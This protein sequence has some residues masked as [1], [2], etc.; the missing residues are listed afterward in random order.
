[1][2]EAR[3]AAEPAATAD[4]P[5]EPGEP[6]FDD[7]YEDRM[8]RGYLRPDFRVFVG[9]LP[10]VV[11]LVANSMWSTQVAIAASFV[12]ATIVF[13]R[14]PGSGVIRALTMVSFVVVFASAVVGLAL[15]SGK[16]FVAQNMVGDFLIAAIFTGSVIIGRPM[17][18][19][20]AREMVPAIQPIMAIDHQVFVKLTLLNAGVNLVTG[21]MRLFLLDALTENQYVIV[22]RVLGFPLAAAFF[23][24]AYREITRAAI[25]I[26][27]VDEPPPEQ[28]RPARR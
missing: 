24:Y 14:Y 25:R 3:D 22:S 11:F 12:V 19:A 6:E 9:V 16:A 2:N 23:L 15:D 20:I 21:I 1:M 13:A 8:R 5:V 18:G 10:S 17:I 28:W 26:W 7:E 4:P 27:P